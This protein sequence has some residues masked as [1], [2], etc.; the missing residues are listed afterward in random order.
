MEEFVDHQGLSEH[1][2]PAL[3]L[4][5]QEGLPLTV[6]Q[7]S[8]QPSVSLFSSANQP[9]GTL[10][11]LASPSCLLSVLMLAHPWDLFYH[12]LESDEKRALF[13]QLPEGWVSTRR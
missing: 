1:L 8:F 9:A 13:T 6:S 5:K 2:S 12:Q 3:I 4:S 10:L 7:D 11:S